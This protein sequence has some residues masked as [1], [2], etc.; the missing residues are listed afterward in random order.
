MA[1]NMNYCRPIEDGNELEYA[2]IILPP[3]TSAP[4]EQEYNNAGWYRNAVEQPQIPEGKIV[5]SITY[6]YDEGLNAI[7][8]DYIFKDAPIPVRTFSKLKLYAA[9]MQTGLWTQFETWLK[10]QTINGMN[11][12]T[13]FSL[14]QDLSDEN[15]LFLGVVE[16]AKTALGVSDETVQQI[17]NASVYDSF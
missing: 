14:A 15:E 9:L 11:A 10:T 3:S 4:T 16:S 2:P 8:A 1:V 12:Y 6:R 7:V 17:L 5:T 13:A